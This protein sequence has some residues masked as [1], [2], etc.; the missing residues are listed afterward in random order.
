MSHTQEGN[1][2]PKTPAGKAISRFNAERHAILR[3]TLTDYE[4]TDAE[5]LY[6]DFADDL[7][8][9]GRT[10]EL[11][12]EI[13]ASN[14]V[15]LHRIAKA[16]GEAMKTALSPNDLPDL[17]FMQNGYVPVVKQPLAEQLMLY[18]R[19]QT[20]TENRI[21]RSLAMLYQLKARENNK[22]TTE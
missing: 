22:E 21:Y 2:G 6:N 16:E 8:P 13:L 12:V 9:T 10:Q 19:Y 20:A 18:S 4:K 11:L 3:E 1:G 15:R 14:A 17:M 7:V 5:G